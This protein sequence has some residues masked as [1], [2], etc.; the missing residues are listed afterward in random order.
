[1]KLHHL[2]IPLT[3]DYYYSFLNSKVK[4]TDLGLYILDSLKANQPEGKSPAMV[5]EEY[6]DDSPRHAST[7]SKK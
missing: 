5:V 3:G 7:S 4:L 1:M 6:S 2:G